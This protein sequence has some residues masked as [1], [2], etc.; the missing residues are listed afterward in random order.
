M[1]GESPSHSLSRAWISALWLD[2]FRASFTPAIIDLLRNC[3][4]DV[5]HHTEMPVG[6]HYLN[7]RCLSGRLIGAALCERI[8]SGALA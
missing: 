5:R 4:R 8:S 1:R 7:G 2:D 6:S 3:G